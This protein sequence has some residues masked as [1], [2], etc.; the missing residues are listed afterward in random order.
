MVVVVEKVEVAAMVVVLAGRTE[1][2]P[3]E[4]EEG[5]EEAGM[6]EVLEEG[7][8]E[9][10]EEEVKEKEEEEEVKEEE[11]KEEEEKKEAEEVVK[12]EEVKEV[13]EEEVVTQVKQ[14]K[15]QRKIPSHY[16]LR[17]R[18]PRRPLRPL[19]PSHVP[20]HRHPR[21]QPR[22]LQRSQEQATWA[23]R[24]STNTFIK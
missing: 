3:V 5:L 13:K 14:R 20:Q 11:V 24:I 22:W 4:W 21:Q 6:V 8:V 9:G 18:L 23:V 2:V 15:I 1:K 10:E 7:I 12:E 19:R 16:P 17:A